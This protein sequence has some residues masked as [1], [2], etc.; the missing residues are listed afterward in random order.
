[1]KSFLP[2]ILFI[3][4][5]GLAKAQQHSAILNIQNIVYGADQFSSKDFGGEGTR[6]WR[7]FAEYT[8]GYNYVDKKNLVLQIGMGYADFNYSSEYQSTDNG[9]SSNYLSGLSYSYLTAEAGIGKSIALT[10]AFECVPMVLIAYNQQNK[11][12]QEA[13]WTNA[14]GGNDFG[15][16]ILYSFPKI[17]V[18]QTIFQTQFNYK[19]WQGLSLGFAPRF[20]IFNARVKGTEQLLERYEDQNGVITETSLT[21]DLKLNRMYSDFGGAFVLK[22]RIF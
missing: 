17:H 13:S 8:L 12:K 14:G 15:Y 4:L 3:F 19:I 2:C 6:N 9:Q 1:M 22:Y 11:N 7:P 10:D 21:Q 18:Y 20:S 5:F 16:Q